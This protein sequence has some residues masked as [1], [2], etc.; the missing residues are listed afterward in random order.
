VVNNYPVYATDIRPKGFKVIEFDDYITDKTVA[1][2][3]K[4]LA[5][6][7]L[8]IEMCQHNYALATRYFSFTLLKDK[9][10]VLVANAC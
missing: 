9:L 4:V 3:R 1:M 7:K 5:N 6:K 2:T 8:E 10:K